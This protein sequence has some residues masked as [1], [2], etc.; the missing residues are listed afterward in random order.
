MEN[1]YGKET[2]DLLRSL[3]LRKNSL[4]RNFSSGV[5]VVDGLIKIFKK[6]FSE[7]RF[8]EINKIFESKIY[9]YI[10]KEVYD[11][12]IKE[13]IE[14]NNERLERFGL[15]CG[16]AKSNNYFINDVITQKELENLLGEKIK[17]TEDSISNLKIVKTFLEKYQ[18]TVIADFHTHRTFEDC[19]KISVNDVG[20]NDD[21]FGKINLFFVSAFKDGKHYLVPYTIYMWPKQDLGYYTERTKIRI[22]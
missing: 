1:L 15:L 7:Q 20:N 16:E 6:D 17:A 10:N 13:T 12:I 22:I 14:A 4:E 3:E 5:L 21:F 19:L 18:N 9:V 11:K 2:L 8:E